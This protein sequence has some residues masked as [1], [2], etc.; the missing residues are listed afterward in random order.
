M[1]FKTVK[2]IEIWPKT[3]KTRK[4]TRAFRK[5]DTRRGINLLYFTSFYNS[6]DKN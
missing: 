5:R 1:E 2:K 6:V 4:F 3:V